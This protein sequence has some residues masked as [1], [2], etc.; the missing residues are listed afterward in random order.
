MIQYGADLNLV[1]RIRD[2]HGPRDATPLEAALFHGNLEI[3]ELL[4][5]S[6]AKVLPDHL[7]AL[8]AP[9][10]SSTEERV[11]WVLHHGVDVNS[12]HPRHGT[13]LHYVV[14]YNKRND[15]KLLLEE[16]ADPMARPQTPWAGTTPRELLES[17]E[18]DQGA[19]ERNQELRE[20]LLEAE[21]NATAHTQ[22]SSEPRK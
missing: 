1:G 4:V 8:M 13:A 6:G 11:R 14:W 22:D 17:R 7:F 21:I 10:T 20:L 5:S 15:V 19:H 2:W 12:P 9:R 16:G 18:S 3:C